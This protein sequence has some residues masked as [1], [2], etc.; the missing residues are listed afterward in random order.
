G[1]D[2]RRA[3]TGLQQAQEQGQKQQLGFLGLDGLQQVLGGGLVIQ[4][5]GK[6]RVGQ[7]QGV[8]FL[9]Q[10]VRLGEGI[11]VVD[12]RVFHAVEQHV[13][14]ADAQHGG[15]EVIAVEGGFV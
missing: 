2:H 14:A 11:L 8:F 1:H 12:V 4:A 3:A 7:D 5:A 9:I 13:H 6:G 15:V 10:I